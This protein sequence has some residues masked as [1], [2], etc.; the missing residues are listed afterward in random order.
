[1]EETKSLDHDKLAEYIRSHTF[2][3]V[4]GEITYNKDGDWTQ[5][6]TVFT[7]FQKVA[8]NNLDQFRD[9]RHQVIL[10]PDRYKTGNIIY[11]YAEARK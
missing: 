11:P 8:P 6:R 5:P 1:V 10:W 2:A 3:T 7:Q 4:A 9:T